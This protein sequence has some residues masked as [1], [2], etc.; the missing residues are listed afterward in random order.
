[1]QEE[2]Y[3][4]TGGT[5]DSATLPPRVI[6]ALRNHP[7][8]LY[9][10]AGG[11]T[12]GIAAYSDEGLAN[13]LDMRMVSKGNLR[14]ASKEYALGRNGLATVRGVTKSTNSRCALMIATFGDM[15]TFGIQNRVYRDEAIQ[16]QWVESRITYDI[17]QP[18]REAG[19]FMTSIVA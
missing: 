17:V 6:R 11:Q 5:L 19:V 10:I 1:M 7:G 13:V 16:G 9:R 12:N 8:L 3:A 4:A 15:G 2:I 14:N 18:D